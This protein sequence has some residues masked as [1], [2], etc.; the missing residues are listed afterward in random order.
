MEWSVLDWNESA[1]GF[2][3]RLGARLMTDWRICRMT[4]ES[5]ARLAASHT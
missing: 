3:E 4:S 2:Y 1:I 5:L